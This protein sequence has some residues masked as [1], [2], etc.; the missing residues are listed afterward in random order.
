LVEKN[1]N[2]LSKQN[3]IKSA[4]P[5]NENLENQNRSSIS[6]EI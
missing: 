6:I 5:T 3:E 2:K 4:K 1:E